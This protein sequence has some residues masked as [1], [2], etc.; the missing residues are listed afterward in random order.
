MNDGE[1]DVPERIQSRAERKSRKT[2]QNI[3]L[4]KVPGI[5]RVTLR[6]PRGVRIV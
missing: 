2:L 5:Q 4:K 6:R 1:V 3:G